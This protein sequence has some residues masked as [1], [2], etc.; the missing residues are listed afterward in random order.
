M[1]AHL[2]RPPIRRFPSCSPS[3][4]LLALLAAIVA[5]AHPLYPSS[6]APPPFLCPALTH[7]NDSYDPADPSS[8]HHYSH[9][10]TPSCTGTAPPPNAP[11]S[12]PSP[13]PN[14]ERDD[15]APATDNRALPRK[16]QKDIDGL[17]REVDRY[18]L[19]GST[20]CEWCKV[21]T[22]VMMNDQ[23]QSSAP[24][25]PKPSS[26]TDIADSLP[27]GWKPRATVKQMPLILSVSLVLAFA[28]CILIIGSLF[29]KRTHH[30]KT[31]KDIDLE[32]KLGKGW[33]QSSSDQL[34]DVDRDSMIIKEKKGKVAKKLWARATARWK[35]NA[36][37]TA[38]QRR[39]KRGVIVRSLQ[40]P[41]PF[42]VPFNQQEE[43][44]ESSSETVAQQ[45][46]IPGEQSTAEMETGI[47]E[48]LPSPE[49]ARSTL[50]PAY[51]HGS[52]NSYLEAP[53]E[54]GRSTMLP[55]L[56]PSSGCSLPL[57]QHLRHAA[58]VATDDKAI[59]AQMARLVSTPP[60][61]GYATSGV[62]AP[63]WPDDEE[64]EIDRPVTDCNLLHYGD[65]L[66]TSLSLGLPSVLPS[67]P[68]RGKMSATYFDYTLDDITATEAEAEPSAP[69]FEEAIYFPPPA[70]EMPSAPPVSLDQPQLEASAPGWEDD[71]LS[72]SESVHHEVTHSSRLSIA[73]LPEQWPV[74]SDERLPGYQS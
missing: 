57:Q 74:N 51:H 73:E 4:S 10:P 71:A 35:A 50:P 55:S 72:V 47:P 68:T 31:P 24:Y 28:I 25:D 41:D 48:D 62:S 8:S 27:R 39:G 40:T 20:I 26:T 66:S 5:D 53:S 54:S 38:R 65:E 36:R 17:W 49:S 63:V 3:S 21:P 58:H 6:S 59:L 18:T 33:G 30:R 19:Y 23:I 9:H 70:I 32:M 46:Q 52:M 29:L 12:T 1:S 22:G 45:A 16:Y 37:Y 64:E 11:T 7:D 34:A 15:P 56:S 43:P 69:S 61:D 2:S 67:P 13:Q 42:P 44:P 60:A 14:M